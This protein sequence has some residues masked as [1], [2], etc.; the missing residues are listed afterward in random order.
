MRKNKNQYGNRFAKKDSDREASKPMEMTD[1]IAANPD[2]NHPENV[3]HS[4]VPS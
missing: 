4:D 2:K 1:W 3:L